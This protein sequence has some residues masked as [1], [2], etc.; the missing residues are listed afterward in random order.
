MYWIKNCLRDTKSQSNGVCSSFF[1]VI[2]GVPVLSRFTFGSLLIII[3][4]NNSN[5]GVVNKNFKICR[6][7]KTVSTVANDK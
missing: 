2:C 4:I 3:F 5:D 7:H 1:V 6:R